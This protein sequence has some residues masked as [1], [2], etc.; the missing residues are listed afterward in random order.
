[1]RLSGD[2]QAGS[3]EKRTLAGRYL[4]VRSCDHE[5]IVTPKGKESVYLASGESYDFGVSLDG[6]EVIVKSSVDVVNS[7]VVD[8]NEGEIKTL[9]EFGGTTT[10]NTSTTV[11]NGNS[12]NDLNSVTI[13]A[14]AS[15]LIANANESRQSL[16]VS[17]LSSEKGYV[18]LGGYQ[19]ASATG[20]TL[21]AGQI[22]YMDTRGAVY[23]FNASAEDVT[24][25][26]MEI[27]KL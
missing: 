12:N 5:L 21:E 19:V 18:N 11:E 3:Q 22:D 7:F 4:L 13:S 2:I 17:M 26:V 9:P 14:G 15:A 1:M 10:I 16:R 24:V 23:A 27:N 25:Y 20:G 6:V 8:S